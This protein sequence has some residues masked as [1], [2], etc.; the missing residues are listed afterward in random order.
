MPNVS[1]KTNKDIGARVSKVRKAAKKTQEWLA[2]RLGVDPNYI[3]MIETGKRPLTAKN[4]QK[5]AALFPPVRVQWLIGWDDFETEDDEN[6]YERQQS[7]RAGIMEQEMMKKIARQAGYELSYR[8]S[9]IGSENYILSSGSGET[10]GLTISEYL[11]FWYD[12]MDYAVFRLKRTIE[13]KYNRSKVT[14]DMGDN[15]TNE[16]GTD[17]G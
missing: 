1:K 15:P 12:F 5:I 14:I 9:S 3:S 4:A 13:T 17:N 16:G 7:Q 2:E 8:D 6:E 10:V 11:D